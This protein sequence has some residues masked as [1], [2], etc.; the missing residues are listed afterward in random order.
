MPAISG[1]AADTHSEVERVEVRLYRIVNS[2]TEYWNGSAWSVSIVNLTTTLNPSSG[3]TS[4]S[5][6][7]ASGWPSGTSLPDG[8]YYLRA[9][10]YD[11]VGRTAATAALSFKKATSASISAAISSVALSTAEASVSSQSLSLTFTGAINEAAAENE[12]NY[13]ISANGQAVVAEDA[14]YSAATSTVTLRLPQ[15]SLRAGTPVSVSSN[16][17]DAAGA[18]VSGQIDLLAE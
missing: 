14:S 1:M 16:L 12:S 13:S 9:F 18:A 7:R 2:V 17:R 4:V 6:S 10:A 5:W 8:T 11:L 15:G 3:G